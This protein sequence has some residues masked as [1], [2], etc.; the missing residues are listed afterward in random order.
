MWSNPNTTKAPI[1]PAP[2]QS[3][4]SNLPPSL[5]NRFTPAPQSSSSLLDCVAKVDHVPNQKH[6]HTS[7][8]PEHDHEKTVWLY[9]P[10]DGRVTAKD[11]WDFMNLLE[12]LNI[13]QSPRPVPSGIKPSIPGDHFNFTEHHNAGKDEDNEIIY[14]CSI[15][16]YAL[17][18]YECSP[19]ISNLSV[20]PRTE[21]SDHSFLTLSLIVPG[22]NMDPLS[23]P[24]SHCRPK[25]FTPLVTNLDFL[26]NQ[27]L[28]CPTPTL[29]QN[30]EKL[31]GNA[32]LEPHPHPS[33]FVH[34]QGS[35]INPGQPHATASSGVFFGFGSLLNCSNRVPGSQSKNR[36]D[37]FAVL[38]ALRLA[39][40][41]RPLFIHTSSKFLINSLT[42]WAPARARCGWSCTDSDLLKCITLVITS[43]SAPVKLIK[44]NADSA[45]Q[46]HHNASSLA[47]AAC[48]LPL[49]PNGDFDDPITAPPP[50]P[51]NPPPTS[52]IQPKISTNLPRNSPPGPQNKTCSYN[53]SSA[54]NHCHQPLQRHLQTAMRDK[55]VEASV[56]LAAFWKIYIKFC[57]PS[58]PPPLVS[59]SDLFNCFHPRLNLPDPT[60]SQFNEDLLRE[61]NTRV[62]NRPR[63]SAPSIFPILNEPITVADIKDLKSH[64]SEHPHSNTSGTDESTY[65]LILELD[66]DVLYLSDTNNYHA[67]ALE[68]C[69]LKFGTLLI[70]Q[71]LTKAAELGHLIPP[72][73]NGFRAGHRTHNNAFILRSLIECAR[74]HND[75]F[76]VAF[77]N[78]SN[79]FPSTN[80][81][82]HWNCLEDLG[83]TG[84]YHNWLRS[85]YSNMRYRLI[86]GEQSSEDFKAG[87]GVLMGDP[88]SPMLW[89]LYLSTF[90]LP[91]HK[92]DTALNGTTISHLEHADDMVIISRCPASLQHHFDALQL[93]CYNNFLTLSPSKSEVMIFGDIRPHISEVNIIE[94]IIGNLNLSAPPQFTVNGHT[95]RLT[96]HFKY[97]GITFCSVK[98]DIFAVVYNN[99]SKAAT[100]SSH[101]ILGTERLVGRGCLPPKSTKHLY[102]ALV[103][104]HL[105]FGCEIVLDITDSAAHH[106][107]KVQH[108][109]FCRILGL[110]NNSIL[111]PLYTETGIRPICIHRAT[112]AL[113]YLRYLLELPHDK[114]AHVALQ[115]LLIL[116]SRKTPC[117]L[118]NLDYILRHLPHH[119]DIPPLSLPPNELL[120]PSNMTD[121][122]KQVNNSSSKFLLWHIENFSHLSLLRGRVEPV[123]PDSDS[124][125][126]SPIVYFRHYLHR[127]THYRHQRSLTRLLCGNVSPWVFRCAPG[128]TPHNNNNPSSMLCHFCNM[129]YE[130]PEHVLLQCLH[131]PQI[132]SL[133]SVFLS[134][135][136][137]DPLAT[138]SNSHAL[139]LLKCWIFD[140][141]LVAATAALTHNVLIIWKDRC[142]ISRICEIWSDEQE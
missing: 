127:V 31:Y 67:I 118:S 86:L 47:K 6:T 69:F 34:T 100:I 26:L 88:A 140:W 14:Q 40:P 120:T 103:D 89:N 35:C 55:I 92:H 142:G 139:E 121:L 18:S 99:K 109:F 50:P 15:I 76:Y 91:P 122:I 20:S 63:V 124:T 42:Y 101:G 84:M 17:A 59:L 90:S 13:G 3:G 75:T 138:R 73:Q 117:W 112:L 52:C 43:C 5:L 98:K 66:N 48:N 10:H 72:S 87:S 46:H 37:L 128:R 32:I 12:R 28:Q 24:H 83:L 71:R 54:A 56:S 107:K 65:S 82:A 64:L 96:D 8:F 125:P 113:S 68:S 111:T 41:D 36:T 4:S 95:L 81:S 130:T 134:S 16:D 93:W 44:V 27:L 80:H 114:L 61:H 110:S 9:R 131:L 60:S 97:V 141:N 23:T 74:D 25:I 39:P 29:E 108:V 1:L 115:S 102:T 2:Q 51:F 119:P 49:P 79:A 135:I 70:L 30:W 104:C 19:F 133:R 129:S 62:Q 78:I 136:H 7:T 22:G 94:Y 38:L 116:H 105:I 132:T 11:Y 33:L 57:Y 45:N 58:T 21:W 126:S 85:L 106:L 137:L 77:V 123:D 53:P